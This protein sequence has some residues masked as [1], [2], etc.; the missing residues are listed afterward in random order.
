MPRNKIETKTHRFV[1][2]LT[3]PMYR[4]IESAAFNDEISQAELIRRAVMYYL[5]NLN[6]SK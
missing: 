4:L 3:E 6:E 2:P 5:E 1:L